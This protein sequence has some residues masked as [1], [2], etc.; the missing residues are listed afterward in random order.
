MESFSLSL[1]ST[2]LALA[3]V[4]ALA[5]LV[6]RALRSRMQARA[7]PGGAGDDALRFVR[8]LAVGAKERVVIIE[9]RGA[10]WMLG[11]T[12]GSIRTIAQWPAATASQGGEVGER[13]GISTGAGIDDREQP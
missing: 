3:V 8:A 12:A 5:W 1:A 9:H 4:I 6:L 10:R 11:V 13:T 2:L 7:S